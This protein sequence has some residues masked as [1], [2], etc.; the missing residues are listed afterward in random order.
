MQNK[1]IGTIL[2]LVGIASFFLSFLFATGFDSKVGF[3]G[4]IGRMEFVLRENTV[5]KPYDDS[6]YINE[7]IRLKMEKDRLEGK[8]AKPGEIF[9]MI[10]DDPQNKRWQE[11]WEGERKRVAIPY[12]FFLTVDIITIFTGLGFLIVPKKQP[13]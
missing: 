10:I 6:E 7:M 12:K 3:L 13:S 1:R 2:I 11:Y 4:S 5:S 8:K 9:Q